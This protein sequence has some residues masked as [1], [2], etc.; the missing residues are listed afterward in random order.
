MMAN[1]GDR[2]AGFQ[3]LE[4]WFLTSDRSLPGQLRLRES[5]KTVL[6]NGPLMPLLPVRVG[7]R[8]SARAE[9]ERTVSSRRLP[10]RLSKAAVGVLCEPT[11]SA[12]L[13]IQHPARRRPLGGDCGT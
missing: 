10:A 9:A 4:A 13:C 11:R 8:L 7:R 5:R 6:Y 3:R 2:L 12:M 1:V